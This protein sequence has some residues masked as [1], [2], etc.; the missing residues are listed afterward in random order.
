MSP[1][2]NLMA[3]HSRANEHNVLNRAPR[4]PSTRVR[5]PS[6][7]EHTENS[8]KAILEE[9]S[10]FQNTINNSKTQSAFQTSTPS[11]KRGQ[12]VRKVILVEFMHF[13]LGFLDPVGGNRV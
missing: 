12:L 10:I 13:T 9:F 3:T 8:D 1:L 7:C 5:H 6:R 11:L 4:T 2:W